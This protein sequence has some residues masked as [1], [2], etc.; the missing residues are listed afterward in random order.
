MP[1]L[2]FD[3]AAGTLLAWRKQPGDTVHRGE[4]IA[5]VDTDKAAVEVEAFADGVLQK[6]FVQPG[7]R[8]PVGTLLAI[9]REEG[10]LLEGLVAPAPQE[11]PVAVPPSPPETRRELPASV[12]SV[13]AT[14]I[15]RRLA[16]ELGIDLSKV[17]GT[18]P[19][20][21]IQ[22]RD[23]RDAA[24][25]APGDRQ[26][27]MREAIAAAMS[28]SA[29]E[30]PHFHVSETIDMSRSLGMAGQRTR[31]GSVADRLLPRSCC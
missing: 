19:G 28:R 20:G 5:E 8:V 16:E 23:V 15:A 11:L 21:R 24:A 13:R 2:G 7:E 26:A 30:I 6:V 1:S 17:T 22:E 10:E 4:V 12:P 27:R 14:P 9:I 31:E 25:A 18:G 3:M 29:R